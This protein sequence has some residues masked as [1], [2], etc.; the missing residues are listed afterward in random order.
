M[1]TQRMAEACLAGQQSGYPKLRV[2]AHGMSL[3]CC[4]SLSIFVGCRW[5]VSSLQLTPPWWYEIWNCDCLGYLYK[6][7]A[8]DDP[9]LHG[10]S[11]I[12]KHSSRLVKVIAGVPVRSS[13][14]RW[15]K[16]AQAE[17]ARAHVP[18]GLRKERAPSPE[19]EAPLLHV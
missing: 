19:Q 15:Q 17:W 16:A 7:S 9:F 3:K 8:P 4:P 18:F 13:S 12:V 5:G 2:P 1:H 10:L 11:G 6:V 14:P